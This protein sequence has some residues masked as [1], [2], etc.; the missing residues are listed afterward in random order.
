MFRSPR[1]VGTDRPPE[2]MGTFVFTLILAY[3][4]GSIPTSILTGKFVGGID[5]RQYGSGNAGATN[6]YRVL[7]LKP[8]LFV[9]AVDGFKGFAATV[10]ISRIA[11][12]AVG[13]SPLDISIFSGMA[14]VCGHIW[15]VFAGFRG[16][17]GVATGAGML[18]GIIPF[19][20]LGGLLVYLGVVAA[21]GYVSLGSILAALFIPAFLMFQMFY[22]GEEVPIE[23]VAASALLSL[24]ILFTH[25]ANISRLFKGEENR[26]RFFG[27]R[28]PGPDL[29]SQNPIEPLTKKHR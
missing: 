22:L 6:V 26:V 25:R 16:G 13:L 8:Y 29:N 2:P 5:I 23:I 21:A 14:A 4:L 15:T 7:G 19:S 12:G 20:V 24:L 11:V 17:K 27:K 28:D 3:L 18:L 1:T 10:Y 9:L